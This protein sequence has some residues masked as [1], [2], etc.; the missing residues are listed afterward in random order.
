MTQ[1]KKSLTYFL[2]LIATFFTF[3]QSAEATATNFMVHGG[4][5]VVKSLNLAID[6]H[7]L[8]RFT[9]VGQSDH[10]LFFL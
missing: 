8:I 4:E 5:E 9:V 1:Y 10:T 7:V 3:A 6:D 2:L